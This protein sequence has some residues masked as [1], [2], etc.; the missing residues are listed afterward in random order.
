MKKSKNQLWV[1]KMILEE[2]ERHKKTQ[3]V[4]M[5]EKTNCHIASYC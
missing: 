2:N 5:N 3:K 1:K 4:K